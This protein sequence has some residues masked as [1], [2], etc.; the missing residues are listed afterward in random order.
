MELCPA[1]RASVQASH[2][3]SPR[4]VRKVCRREYKTNGRTGFTLFSTACSAI[5]LKVLA[6]CFLRLED[7]T[8]PLRVGA[9]HTQPSTGFPA[10]SQRASSMVLT[11]RLIGSTRRAA[12]VLP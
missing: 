10:A 6:C 3:D 7:T 9:G 5:V 2:P 11:L 4:R 1:I 8:W 12:A